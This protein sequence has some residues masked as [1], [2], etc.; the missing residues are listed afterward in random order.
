[1]QKV[2]KAAAKLDNQS[3]MTPAVEI[4]LQISSSSKKEE[5]ESVTDMVTPLR[6]LSSTGKVP[7]TA[8]Q[9]VY[10]QLL[11]ATY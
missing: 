8:Y 10:S 4:G 7:N 9:T 1:M 3:A 2:D 11:L 6:S 5:S